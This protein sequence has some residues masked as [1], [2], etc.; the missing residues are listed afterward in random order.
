MYW[1]SNSTSDERTSQSNLEESPLQDRYNQPSANEYQEH[2]YN[3]QAHENHSSSSYYQDVSAWSLKDDSKTGWGPMP[4]TCNIPHDVTSG[5]HDDFRW[6]PSETIKEEPESYAAHRRLPS[7]M[8]DLRRKQSW[9]KEQRKME[10]QKRTAASIYAAALSNVNTTAIEYVED[11]ILLKRH[12]DSVRMTE[13]VSSRR[14]RKRK[15]EDEDE[16]Q[17]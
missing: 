12:A 9:E 3:E 11:G 2:T 8:D 17:R 7:M 16:E 14:G 13:I 10:K 6:Q 15:H 5:S 4:S 1:I